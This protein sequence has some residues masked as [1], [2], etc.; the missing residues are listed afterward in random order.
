[1]SVINIIIT[2]QSHNITSLKYGK[3]NPSNHCYKNI[4]STKQPLI[5]IKNHKFR[6]IV[7]PFL[8]TTISTNNPQKRFNPTY[9]LVTSKSHRLTDLHLINCLSYKFDLSH[10]EK[11]M[12]FTKTN[13]FFKCLL[14]ENKFTF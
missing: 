10:Y 6:R 12:N 4:W 14:T 2:F 8:L 9:W 3:E 5:N 11:Q 7:S 1:M 13:T